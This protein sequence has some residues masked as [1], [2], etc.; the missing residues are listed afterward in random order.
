MDAMDG[1][2]GRGRGSDIILLQAHPRGGFRGG[3]EVG[4]QI[5]GVLHS[6]L[7][8]FHFGWIEFLVARSVGLKR[9][10]GGE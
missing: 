4:G 3:V 2:E 1:A 10:V 5:G 7:L 9:V 8:P 6:N